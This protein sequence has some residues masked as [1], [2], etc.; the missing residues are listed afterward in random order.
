MAAV[1][2]FAEK[3]RQ[4]INNQLKQTAQQILGM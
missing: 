1:I 2:L 3:R 4:Q